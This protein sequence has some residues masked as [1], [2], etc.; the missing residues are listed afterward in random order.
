MG[1]DKHRDSGGDGN[2]D[3]HRNSGAGARAGAGA[4]AGAGSGSRGALRGVVRLNDG[5]KKTVGTG[6][7]G[8]AGLRAGRPRDESRDE[9]RDRP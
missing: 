8:D 4:N 7:K 9:L 1:T 2:G 5:L 6:E 3:R